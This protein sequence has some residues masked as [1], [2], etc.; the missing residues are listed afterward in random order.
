MRNNTSFTAL[1]FIVKHKINPS[2][3][4][5]ESRDRLHILS[6][7]QC[8]GKDSYEVFNTTIYCAAA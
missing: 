7:K 1:A 8:R 6:L 4:N 5:V 2:K 3:V